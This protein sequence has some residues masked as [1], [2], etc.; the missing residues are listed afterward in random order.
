SPTFSTRLIAIPGDG[1]VLITLNTSSQLRRASAASVGDRSRTFF[2]L[3]T[4]P[5]SPF[6]ICLTSPCGVVATNRNLSGFTIVMSFGQLRSC[7]ATRRPLITI[8]CVAL[9]ALPPMVSTYLANTCS[10]EGRFVGSRATSSL[11]PGS[12]PVR[13]KDG[14]G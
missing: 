3:I 12:C 7:D 6:T 1:F 8:V 2:P 5:F 11:G 13:F 9:A 14:G 4:Q 10:T